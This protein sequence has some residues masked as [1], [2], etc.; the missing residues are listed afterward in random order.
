MTTR[1]RPRLRI[2]LVS[3]E[4]PTARI[5]NEAV[6]AEGGELIPAETAESA[7]RRVR[8]ERFDA[9]FADTSLPN[10]SR[11]GFTRVVRKSK[12]NSGALI[13]LLAGL[14]APK[15]GAPGPSVDVS[16][17]AKYALSSELP[18]LLKSLAKKLMADRRKHRR[19]SFR[20]QVN[21]IQGVRRF[22]ATSVNLGISGLL[23]ESAFPVEL[24]SELQ[25]FFNLVSGEHVLQT[26][27]QVVRMDVGNRVGVA[28]Q[29]LGGFERGRLRQFLDLH[30]P[31]IR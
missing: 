31:P 11:S 29:N 20:A 21:C 23:L 2:L 3:D 22:R 13:V 4:A 27:G 1:P 17:M 6:S 5:F 7:P 15:G 25:L 14:P 28:F 9:I 8:D 30:L 18:P 26:R 24:G 16:V 19:L 10:F 12:L